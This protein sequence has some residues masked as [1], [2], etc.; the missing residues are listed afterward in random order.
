MSNLR[1]VQD[2]NLHKVGCSHPTNLSPNTPCTAPVRNTG[3]LKN[4]VQTS[5]CCR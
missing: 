1:C 5:T 4:Q 3:L 2:S